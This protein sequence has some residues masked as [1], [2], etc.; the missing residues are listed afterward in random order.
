MDS[1]HGN[2]WS[3]YR[4]HYILL[5]ALDNP[6]GYNHLNQI[7]GDDERRLYFL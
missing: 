1:H 6:F 4:L 5:S 2:I 7:R 3:G